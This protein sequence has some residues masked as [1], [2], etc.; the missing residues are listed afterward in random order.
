MTVPPR[1]TQ[2]QFAFAGFAWTLVSAIGLLVA[3]DTLGQGI[4]GGQ[5]PGGSNLTT[6]VGFG[7][8]GFGSGTGGGLGNGSFGSGLGQGGLGQGGLGQ[9]GLGQGGFGQSGFGGGT[10]FG[11]QGGFGQSASGFVGRDSADVAS[12]FENMTRQ[13][14]AFQN[15]VDRAINR[16]GQGDRANNQTTQQK[17]RVKLK[18]GFDYPDPVTSPATQELA[19]RIKQMVSGKKVSDLTIQQEG[20]RVIL[21]GRAADQWE[22]MLVEQLVLQ[23]PSVVSVSNQMTVAEPIDAPTP[24]Q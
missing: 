20:N 24:Q 6:G 16:S 22:R 21:T 3:A 17:V 19:P 18:V 8:S 4:G 15:R 5:L 1:H 7:N 2:R 12:M 10:G 23:Q 9:G 14:Q 13:G 11:S